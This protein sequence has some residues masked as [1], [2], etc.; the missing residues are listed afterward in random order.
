MFFRCEL[1]KITFVILIKFYQNVEPFIIIQMS[2]HFTK[3]RDDVE[4]PYIPS[5]DR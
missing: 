1:Q 2:G 4:C 5:G 3:Y